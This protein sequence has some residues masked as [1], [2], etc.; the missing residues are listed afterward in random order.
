[1][2]DINLY[3]LI[4]SSSGVAKTITATAANTYYQSSISLDPGIYRITCISSTRADL[5]FYS[6]S[7]TY[8]GTTNT[9]SG[10]VDYNLASAAA[11]IGYTVDTGSNILINI[12]LVGNA[13]SG[14]VSGTLDTI[15]STSTYNTTGKLF[16]IAVGGGGGGGYSATN[17]SDWSAC[18][19]ASGGL[20]SGYV[21]TNSATSVTIGAAGNAVT[22]SNG[23]AGGTTTFGSYFTANGG[24]GGIK[25]NGANVT[26]SGG[27]PGGADVNV[28]GA[29]TSGTSWSAYPATPYRFIKDGST[30]TGGSGAWQ[31]KNGGEAGAGSGIGTGGSGGNTSQRGQN[32][33]GYGAGGG[34]GSPR[35]GNSTYAQGGN[36]SPGVVYV[37][38]GF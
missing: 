3:N 32:A 14:S 7:G 36:G 38:R 6:S 4:S 10:T 30:G 2:A 24:G 35:S 21:V 5:F 20:H 37:L 28:Q 1:M 16:V 29:V 31:Y 8:I 17:S 18:G 22:D 19:G 23:N 27:T 25:Y 11:T 26:V 33:N 12:T 34:G 13:F 15:T 9:S